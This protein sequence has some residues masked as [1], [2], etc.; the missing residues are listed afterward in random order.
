MESDW[1]GKGEGKKTVR[2]RCFFLRF[3]GKFSSQ[4]GE[5]SEQKT[6]GFC[7]GPKYPWV[8]CAQFKTTFFFCYTLQLVATIFFFICLFVESIGPGVFFFGLFMLTCFFFFFFL[9]KT[10]G[11][12]FRFFLINSSFFFF[13][14]LITRFS[15]FFFFFF[16]ITGCSFFFFS[17]FF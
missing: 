5:K 14:F 1:L 2:F 15:Y 8:S 9:I 4:I 13:F 10:V 6:S 7:S 12:I 3:T 11:Y 17:F 16:L